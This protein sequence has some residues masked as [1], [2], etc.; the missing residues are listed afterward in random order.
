M[1][2]VDWGL[3]SLE[4]LNYFVVSQKN[5]HRVVKFVVDILRRFELLGVR[6]RNTAV[7]GHSLGAQIAGRIG[8]QLMRLGRPLGAIYGLDPAGPCY[9]FPCVV[10]KDNRLDSGDALYVQCIHSNIGV[11]GQI[12]R[13]GCSDVYLNE[14]VIQPKHV[15]PITAHYFACFLFD[16]TLSATNQCTSV[17]GFEVVGVHNRRVCG[18]FKVKTRGQAPFCGSST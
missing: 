17:D 9:T 14:G 6:M 8:Q 1:C 12:P 16:W 5:T 10:G 7:A 3:L 11:L 18:V 2:A 4:T 13:C 15:D